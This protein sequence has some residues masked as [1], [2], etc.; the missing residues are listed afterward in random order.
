[1]L[2]PHWRTSYIAQTLKSKIK[3][4][5]INIPSKIKQKRRGEREK[6]NNV[7][8]ER[9]AEKAGVV[10]LLKINLQGHICNH[11]KN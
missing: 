10:G 6:S 5:I 9:V 3:K 1:M 2:E 7:E 11:F 4:L 8:R